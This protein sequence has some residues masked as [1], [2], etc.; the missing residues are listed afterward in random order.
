[1]G[2]K[3][4]L[5]ASTTLFLILYLA[6]AFLIDNT[7]YSNGLLMLLFTSIIILG[8]LIRYRE[9]Q[10]I[11]LIAFLLRIFMAFFYTTFGDPD[12]DGYGILAI[13][14][15]SDGFI[16][17]IKEFTPNAHF[18]TWIV[19]ILYSVFGVSELMIRIFNAFLSTLVVIMGY[20]LGKSLY[21]KKAAY[22]IAVILALFPSLIRF[23]SAFP[24]RETLLLFLTMLVLLL[25][26]KF[27]KSGNLLYFISSVFTA[28]LCVALHTSM[29]ILL[30]IVLVIWIY[31]TIYNIKNNKTSIEKAKRHLMLYVGL[32][33]IIGILVAL[34]GLYQFGWGVD[35]LERL[36]LSSDRSF[37]NQVNYLQENAGGRAAYLQSFTFDNPILTVLFSPVR[38]L[39][40]MFTPFIWMVRTPIDLLGLLDALLYLFLTLKAVKTYKDFVKNKDNKNDN[41]FFIMVIFI[42]VILIIGILAVGTS[43][44]GTAIRHRAKILPLLILLAAPSLLK[45]KKSK[46]NVKKRIS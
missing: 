35:K 2:N 21:S 11:I 26:F 42:A 27:Y 43:N 45:N 20:S 4:V 12:P 18:Y 25:I 19:A 14:M 29:V 23:S 36:F 40:F 3:N 44:Y 31:K 17:A 24:N 1:M 16:S 34:L 9:I 13:S 41:K 39:F 7:D 5:I 33:G 28:L 37:V 10:V 38:M 15:A 32:M 6:V 8:C 30:L 22:Y 46:L